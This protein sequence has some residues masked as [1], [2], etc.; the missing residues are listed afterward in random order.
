M[1]TGV[2]R[3][4]YGLTKENSTTDMFSEKQRLSLVCSD[5]EAYSRCKFTASIQSGEKF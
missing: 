5:F 2:Q 3:Y 4:I 1:K